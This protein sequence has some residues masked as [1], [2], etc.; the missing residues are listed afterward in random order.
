MYMYIVQYMTLYVH[1]HVYTLYMCQ[2][3][4][5]VS[6]EVAGLSPPRHLTQYSHTHSHTHTHTA[7]VV[8]GATGRSP[9]LSHDRPQQAQE[10]AQAQGVGRQAVRGEEREGK[11][12]GSVCCDSTCCVHV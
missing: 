11:W 10:Q 8:L 1:V 2:C 12:E 3:I 7:E 9:D 6:M 4:Y 5:L